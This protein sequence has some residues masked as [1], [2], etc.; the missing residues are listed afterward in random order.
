[1]GVANIAKYNLNNR[2]QLGSIDEGYIGGLLILLG[3]N[4]DGKSNVL[5]GLKCWR[6]MKIESNDKPDYID[7]NED[8]E[9]VFEYKIAD[10][11]TRQKI[12]QEIGINKEKV[13]NTNKVIGI[14]FTKE[15]LESGK[16]KNNIKTDEEYFKL[17]ENKLNDS[18]INV[19]H[20]DIDNEW[21]DLFLVKSNLILKCYFNYN[22][23]VLRCVK[24]AE[25]VNDF[26]SERILECKFKIDSQKTLENCDKEFCSVYELLNIVFHTK[27]KL[28][29][30]IISNLPVSRYDN[31][32]YID[33]V[34]RIFDISFIPK[35]VYYEESVVTKEDLEIKPSY[36]GESK[37][38]MTLFK[39]LKENLSIIQQ[40]YAKAESRGEVDVHIL[41]DEEKKIN[42]FFEREINTR[43]NEIYCRG[44]QVYSF[45][46]RFD[47]SK[48]ALRI[49]KNDYSINLDRQSVGFKKFFNL[50]FNFIYTGEIG[51]GDI[52]LIDEPENSMSI[53]AQREIRAF[54]KDF[55][56]N[57]GILFL[58]A[59][60][61]PYMLD[62]RNLD[63]VRIVKSL[64]SLEPQHIKNSK[65]SLIMNYFSMLGAG[66]SDTLNDIR[67]ALG[68]NIE[69]DVT[70]IVFVEGIMD[71]NILNGYSKIYKYKDS[72]KLIFLPISGL[73]VKDKNKE[74]NDTKDNELK[75]SKE[76][77]KKAEGLKKLAK[78]L[79]IHAI[80][81]ADS[82]GA[83]KAMQHGV[84]DD[85]DISKY[86]SV[87]TLRD[88]F[89]V[90][91]ENK[92]WVSKEG[93]KSK[94]IY[95]IETLFSK[96]DEKKF[97]FD[98]CKKKH[99]SNIVSN[100]FKNIEN[101]EKALSQESKDK[102]NEL[103]SYIIKFKKK[104]EE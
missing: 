18:V 67:K 4:N 92:Q 64:S 78:D 90:L 63:E 17:M 91:D 36:I 86:V 3:G 61:S 83:G 100:A 93:F 39:I 96:D 21:V 5:D 62:V 43:F 68:A 32:K 14:Y 46:I 50:F 24:I 55:G 95:T 31:T 59:T 104:S 53:P 42:E 12:E 10:N 6:D 81:L 71:Y 75:I 57:N 97:G 25:S 29:G 82:D 103:F 27:L 51:R 47:S 52:V 1:M 76:Q 2:L 37:F 72:N 87:I 7:H 28:N 23:K 44:E 45:K 26:A 60:H 34:K 8:P 56:K 74:S 20:K 80:L 13:H 85:P 101:L 77:R 94:E 69:L 88:A 84:R 102:F 58:I 9:L 16:T 98:T 54:L 22:D 89:V 79:R 30:Q 40:S 33:V 35:I 41:G 73:G 11:E 65:G 15:V 99:L 38:F 48:I 19:L 70:Q 49:L 66:E